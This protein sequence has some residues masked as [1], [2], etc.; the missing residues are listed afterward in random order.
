MRILKIFSS[1]AFCLPL[2]YHVLLLPHPTLM[3]VRVS[4]CVCGWVGQI[5]TLCCYQS[6]LRSPPLCF[7]LLIKLCIY[8]YS[9]HVCDTSVGMCASQHVWSLSTTMWS[10]LSRFIFA[11]VLREGFRSPSVHT[12]S[13]PAEP[14]NDFEIFELLL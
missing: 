9:V 14:S 5:S 6:V 11:W 10:H 1:P 4:V 7:Y 13:L 3:C 8:Y 2:S 12:N